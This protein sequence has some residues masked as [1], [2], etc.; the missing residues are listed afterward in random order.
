[1]AK[2]ESTNKVLPG[3]CKRPDCVCIHEQGVVEAVDAD[4]KRSQM[5]REH[6]KNRLAEAESLKEALSDEV[7][8]P[9]EESEAQ[10]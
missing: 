2:D 10:E 5:T 1:M 6:A 9:S 4:G 3:T 7:S 8:E